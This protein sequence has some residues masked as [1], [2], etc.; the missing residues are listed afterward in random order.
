MY[1]ILSGCFV[2]MCSFVFSGCSDPVES[3][4]YLS[5]SDV[6]VLAP[7]VMSSSFES[8]IPS[9]PTN[10]CVW[11]DSAGRDLLL[12]NVGLETKNSP[13]D[14]LQVFKGD[15]RV[16]YVIGAGTQAAALF[17]EKEGQDDLEMLMV[18]NRR[19]TLDMR[20]SLVG[21]EDSPEFQQLVVLANKTLAN[22]D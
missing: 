10:F 19:W 1:K 5:L 2:F 18:G 20:S 16:E 12:I 8:R 21:G 3:C 4:D 7:G 13:Y 22:L 6:K 17:S 15:D 11:K 14:I 9:N